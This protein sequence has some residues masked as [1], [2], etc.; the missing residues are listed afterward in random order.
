MNEAKFSMTERSLTHTARKVFESVPIA[1]AWTRHQITSELTRK[2]ISLSP[3]VVSGCLD[4]LRGQGLIREPDR[5]LFSRVQVRVAAPDPKPEGNVVPITITATPKPKASPI[6]ILATISKDLRA[7]AD[8]IDEA[9]LEIEEHQQN[10]DG[11]TK[12]LRQL[13][14]LLKDLA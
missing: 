10:Q 2:G 3:N 14:A 1:E 11:E 6:A 13:Q 8:R 12:K 9:A 7:V 4:S 5:G